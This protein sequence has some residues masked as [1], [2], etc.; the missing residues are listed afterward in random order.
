MVGESLVE[1]EATRATSGHTN[2]N[3]KNVE[4]PLINVIINGRLEFVREV[5]IEREFDSKTGGESVFECLNEKVLPDAC[6]V[7]GV[8][9]TLMELDPL[10]IEA[11][12]SSHMACREKEKMR[13]EAH[14]FI[15][16]PLE[17]NTAI[18][19]I[20]PYNPSD[21]RISNSGSSSSCPFPP[22]YG[23][24]TGQTHCHRQLV[25]ENSCTHWVDSDSDRVGEKAEIQVV[26][27]ATPAGKE[28]G[29]AWCVLPETND[30]ETTG[31]SASKVA[32]G[33]SSLVLGGEP[34]VV[35]TREED[36]R[37]DET[38]YRINVQAF[39]EKLLVDIDNAIFQHTESHHCL[40]GD[41]L[42]V[43]PN[44]EARSVRVGM[45]E[46]SVGASEE[47]KVDGASF[48]QLPNQSQHVNEVLT[49]E[50]NS[51]EAAEAKGVWDKGGIFF[52]SSDE[53]EVVARLTVR[54]V[55]GRK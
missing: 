29:K 23:P 48:N 33:V 11:R 8:R 41:E 30:R 4:D 35:E 40:N 2:L 12:I 43:P 36:E 42:E 18:N 19:K 26:V 53:E 27:C 20:G 1:E 55:E 17:S 37:S 25:R 34:V 44:S 15:Y 14:N 22:G 47:N 24:C 54:K 28:T 16:P 52:D 46:A 38:L 32:D 31:K 49:D 13:G 21:A 51:L 39:N 10:I 5:I 50:D 45:E 7:K 9:S 3:S 6:Y